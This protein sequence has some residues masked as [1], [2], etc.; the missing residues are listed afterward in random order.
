MFVDLDDVAL[1]LGL[2][3]G[4]PLALRMLDNGVEV[5]VVG[6]VDDVKEVLPV[7]EISLRLLLREELGDLGLIH[8]VLYQVNHAELVIAGD[9]DGE[10]L[11]PG[12][13]MLPACEDIL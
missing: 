13:Q 6:G 3:A 12:D 5:L 9:L 8:D 1:F 4:E 7:R 11:G 2:P 10:Q